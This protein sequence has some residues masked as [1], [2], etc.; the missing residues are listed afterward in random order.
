[1]HLKIKKWEKMFGVDGEEM[2]RV[3]RQSNFEL[4]R[5]VSM[6][7]ILCHHYGVHGGFDLLQED[8]SFNML[9]IQLFSFGGKLGVNLFVLISGYFLVTSQWKFRKSVKLWVQVSFY[10]IIILIIA[11]IFGRDIG[12]KDV[13]RNVLP[14]PYIVYWFATTYFVLYIFSDFINIFVKALNKKML[15][16]FLFVLFIIVS[17]IPTFLPGSMKNSEL[18]YLLLLYVIGAYI[19]L[20]NPT[21]LNNKRCLFIG[22]LL[23]A[24]CFA[25]CVVIDLLGIN[26]PAVKAY[27]MYFMQGARTP[28][29]ISSI[30]IFAGFKNKRISNL[31]IINIMAA[32]TF[33]VYLIHDNE[34]VREFLWKTIFKNA[35][36]FQSPLLIVHAVITV[37]LVYCVCTLIDIFYRYVIERAIMK[38]ID[39]LKVRISGDRFKYI[40]E[41][42]F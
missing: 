32:S 16:R 20:Y 5:I 15:L 13:I 37:A 2:E 28:M 7:L 27:A 34:Y 21:V 38:S 31:R 12:L 19:R 14:I 17:I 33:G 9:F 36:Y 8:I 29:F 22:I 6:V 26:I 40:I 18:I 35:S 3:K 24:L 23:Y 4:L 11:I 1:M 25:S 39:K 30:F 41:K 10:S 42:Y